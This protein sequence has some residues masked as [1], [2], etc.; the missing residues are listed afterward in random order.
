[1]A[2]LQAEVP[3]TS[4]N[5]RRKSN[6]R[7]RTRTGCLRGSPSGL[8]SPEGESRAPINQGAAGSDADGGWSKSPLGWPD[9]TPPMGAEQARLVRRLRLEYIPLG[10]CW[11]GSSTLPRLHH[12]HGVA[13]PSASAGWGSCCIRTTAEPSRVVAT[14]KTGRKAGLGLMA[15]I[16]FSSTASRDSPSIPGHLTT[17][18]P[19]APVGGVGRWA[20]LPDLPP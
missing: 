6:W 4:L 14:W 8:L 11:T 2:G 16:R 10:A 20:T 9:R 3:P 12:E 15:T 19:V 17:P 7:A 18:E 13:R 5:R 1:M